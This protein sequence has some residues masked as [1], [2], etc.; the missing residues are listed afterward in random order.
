MWPALVAA[1]ILGL[2]A[3]PIAGAKGAS[4]THKL[5]AWGWGAT[6]QL[7]DGS[8]SSSDVPAKVKLAK[9][10][11]VTQVAAGGYHT[12]AVTSTG[13]VLAWGYNS[14]GQLGDD[15]TT[16]S[17]IPVK[18]KLPKGTKVREVAAG[19]IHSLALT[20]TGAVYAWGYNADGELGDGTTTGPQ[21][22]SSY[23]CSETPVKV[24]L[25]KGTKVTQIAAGGFQSLALTSKGA[26]LAWGEGA[27]GELGDGSYSGSDVPVAVMLPK[28]TKVSQIAAGAFFSL[29]LT[30]KGAVFAWGSNSN[31]Q[32]GD[33]STTETDLPVKV[34]LPKGTNVTEIAG[35][36][37]HS[38]AVTSSGRALAW[39][40]GDDGQLG[41]GNTDDHHLPVKVKLPKGTKL[42]EISGG[43]YFSVA[44]TST[45]AVL[46]WGFNADGELGNAK[47]SQSDLPVKVKLPKGTAATA[48]AT[49]AYAHHSLALLRR[50]R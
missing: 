3:V 33:G 1:L 36:E 41:D 43:S 28:G 39:G 9:G 38:L 19:A 34:K 27:D 11:R 32:L 10:V 46:A 12:L 7:G 18:V 48:I 5:V 50:K 47:T 35:G 16:G 17:Y 21:T 40:S 37:Y 23:P 4:G 44:L 26:V 14:N 49:G 20:S 42:T 22:C 6:G 8:N 15:S 29:A 30:S 24:K 31:G 25:P 45:G 13:A 2:A